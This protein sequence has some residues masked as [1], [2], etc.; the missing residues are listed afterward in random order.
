MTLAIDTRYEY[1][2]IDYGYNYVGLKK[3]SNKFE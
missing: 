2:S 1:L 3:C